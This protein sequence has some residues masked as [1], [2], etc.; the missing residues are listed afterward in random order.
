MDSATVYFLLQ[1][2]TDLPEGQDWLAPGEIDRL[3]SL[4]F[5]KRRND[6]ILGRWTAKRAI[7]SYLAATGRKAPE[8]AALEIRSAPDGAPEALIS[9]RRAPVSLALSHSGKAALCAVCA[10]GC[11]PGC[12]LEEDAPRDEALARDY[13]CVEEKALVDEAP[14]E[15]RS[16]M[17][18]LIWS[19]KESALKCLR[20]GLRR[21]TRSV[22]VE[23]QGWKPSCWNPM[24]VRCRV[25]SQVF[26]GWW[27]KR[28]TDVQTIAS[29][30][31][32]GPPVELTPQ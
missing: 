12:D 5:P 18:T 26:Y 31:P 28:D 7:R 22:Q 16:F 30:Q 1:N 23:I 21:D 24:S 20:E 29:A 3:A 9:G 27:R 4:R 6:W 13:F 32:T 8:F 19:A 2:V 25:S 14:P 17:T 15:E 11:T 10:P